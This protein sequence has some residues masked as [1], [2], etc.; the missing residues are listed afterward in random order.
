MCRPAARAARWRPNWRQR[1]NNPAVLLPKILPLGA[2]DGE[3]GEAGFDNPLD[4]RFSARGMATS[5]AG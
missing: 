3:S 5:S 2:L 1:V 4:P